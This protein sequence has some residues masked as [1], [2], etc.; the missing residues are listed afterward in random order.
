MVATYCMDYVT[1][2]LKIPF[3]FETIGIIDFYFLSSSLRLLN[4]AILPHSPPIFP[5]S[6]LVIF[7]PW[8]LPQLVNL[9][10]CLSSL[11]LPC[12]QYCF[13]LLH[14]QFHHLQFI[15]YVFRE[16][17]RWN[18][19]G[20]MFKHLCQVPTTGFQD[21]THL[22]LPL[23]LPI[24][25]ALPTVSSSC[26]LT[27]STL[28]PSLSC[29]YFLFGQPPSFTNEETDT[30]KGQINYDSACGMMWIQVPLTQTLNCQTLQC[31]SLKNKDIFL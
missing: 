9:T 11:F 8:P 15:S 20:V 26:W 1:R 12:Y 13:C 14:C 23:K 7:D 16:T 19:Y 3:S 31:A 6:R 10:S 17:H 4:G 24:Y 29:A 21:F 18:A 2:W 5:G 25:T 27:S 22:P 30:Q 28:H